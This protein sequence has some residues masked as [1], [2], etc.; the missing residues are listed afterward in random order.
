[1][2]AFP[3]LGRLL[4]FMKRQADKAASRCEPKLRFS[5]TPVYDVTLAEDMAT[6][7]NTPYS[8]PLSVGAH[9]VFVFLQTAKA[10]GTQAGVTFNFTISD[11]ANTNIKVAKSDILSVSYPMYGCAFATINFYGVA[12]AFASA[13]R[14]DQDGGGGSWSP[15]A[16]PRIVTSNAKIIQVDFWSNNVSTQIPAGTQIT[17]YVAKEAE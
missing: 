13:G 7:S 6:S 4:P 14:Q 15:T 9:A 16:L 5:S 11:T 8:I 3:L 2:D 1:M 17:V 10:T 12:H